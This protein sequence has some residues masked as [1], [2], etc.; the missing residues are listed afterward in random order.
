MSELRHPTREQIDLFILGERDQIPVAEL[1]AHFA[2]CD[3]CANELSRQARL[4]SELAEVASAASFCPS[5]ERLS[6]DPRCAHCGCAIEPGGYRVLKVLVQTPHGR[7]YLARGPDGR[8]VALKELVFTQVPSLSMVESFEREGR[9]LQQLRHPRIPKFHGTFTDGDGVHTRLYLAQEY[10]DGE[11]LLAV[12]ARQRFHEDEVIL[13]ARGI[14]EILVYLQGLSPSVFH[15][16]IKPSN[17]IL[18]PRGDVVLVDFGSARDHG[19]TAGGTLAGTFGYMPMEQLVGVVG[20]TSDLFALGATMCH[21]LSRTPPWKLFESGFN[22]SKM[23]ISPAFKKFLAKMTAPKADARFANAAE[24]LDALNALRSKRDKNWGA[25][26]KKA[27]PILAGL[28]AIAVAGATG[29]Y[30]TTKQNVPVERWTPPTVIQ[31]VQPADRVQPAER[32]EPAEPVPPVEPVRPIQPIQPIRPVRPV[33]PIQPVR[34]LEV[35]PALRP[36]PQPR[37]RLSDFPADRRARAREVLTAARRALMNGEMMTAEEG[38]KECLKLAE[39]PECHRNLGVLY[40]QI[41]DT[42]QSIKHYRKYLEISPN[43]QDADYIRGIV[44]GSQQ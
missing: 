21:L 39:L 35:P 2:R 8:R 5:C 16:D 4:E 32:A 14:L 33:Q 6:E 43:A 31:A 24:A 27:A 26:A 20:P 9:I 7:V 10:V 29:F 41:K 15:R 38:F 13:F 25:A 22:A 30:A 28:T 44:E 12:M 1:E 19:A 17:L 36:N 40:A 42:T 23:T 11:S 18:R 3:R 37:P 34:P